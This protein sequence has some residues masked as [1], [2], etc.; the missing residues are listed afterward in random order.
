MNKNFS[1]GR[2][3]AVLLVLAIAAGAAAGIWLDAQP[4]FRDVT[5]SAGDEMPQ[6]EDYMTEYAAARKCAFVT[7][8]TG[9]DSTCVG[10]HQVVLRS[11]AR[12]QTVT[13]RIVDT[14]APELEVQDLQLPLGSE[15]RI[16]DLVT[17]VWD[18]T[19]VTVSYVQEPQITEDYSDL[20][21]EIMAKDTSGNTTVATATVTFIWMHQEFVLEYGNLLTREDLLYTEEM[22]S[23]LITD[24]DLEWL[25]SAP[26]GEHILTS[27]LGDRTQECKITIQ[28]TI[29]PVLELKEVQI[30][31]GKRVKLNDFVVTATD[32]SGDVTL[33]M[34]T[35]PDTS[36][37]GT[38]TIVI[39]AVD[40][41]G[42]VTTAETKLYVVTDVTPPI[43]SGVSKTLYVEK[44]STPDFMEGVSGYDATDGKVAVTVDASRVAM[45]AG[46]TYFLV[47]T[48]RDS[49]GNVTTVRRKVVVSHDE[50]DTAK[51]VQNIAATLENNPET[52]RDY[53]RKSISYSSSWG[54]DDPIWMGFTEKHGNCYVHALC[55]KAILDLKGWNTQLIW[56]TNKTHYWLVIEIEDGVWRHIDATPGNTHS[57]YSLMTDEERHWTLS[58]RNWDRSKWPACE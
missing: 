43:I 1:L 34:L 12:E 25:N 16:E 56:V 10:E 33:N 54:G 52:I 42:N 46:G 7:D 2:I 37:K 47:Y 53:V 6:L 11:G 14:T 22:A 32:A 41:H 8:L 4:Q 15:L 27:T 17:H 57:R 3:A 58:G 23:E 55:L 18:H 24:E 13:L 38:Q 35:T 26:V 49:S 45:N 48:A 19:Q 9:L 39:E 5:I 30:F 50:E 28:D 21:L 31:L 40:A 29:A 36:V 51:L 20:N 44:N